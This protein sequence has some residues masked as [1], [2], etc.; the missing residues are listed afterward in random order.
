VKARDPAQILLKK[1][2][3]QRV[4][5]RTLLTWH[6]YAGIVGPILAILHTGHKFNSSLGIALTAMMI[7][8]TLS[9]FVGRSFVRGLIGRMRTI[10]QRRF[11]RRLSRS[12]LRR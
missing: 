6:I 11:R 12:A 1:V 5:M 8:V 3:T 2:V 10:S 4:S 7:L 9:G